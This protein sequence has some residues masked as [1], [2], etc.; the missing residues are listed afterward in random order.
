[1][2]VLA[3][4]LFLVT[5]LLAKAQVRSQLITTDA[6]KDLIPEGIA[7]DTKTGII[8]ISSINHHSIIAVD[9]NGK[10]QT[11]VAKDRYGFL[12]GLGM[13]VDEKRNWLWAVS[14]SKDSSGSVSKVHAFDIKT[15]KAVQQYTLKDTAQHLLNDL[16]IARD[17]TVYLTDTYYSAVYQLSPSTQKLE[18]FL[19]SPYLNYPNGLAFGKLEQLYIA[20]YE[21]GLMQ[22]NTTTKDLKPL[23]G[24]KDTSLSHGLDGLVFWNNTLIGVYNAGPDRSTNAIVQY[25]LNDKGDRIIK[26]ALLAKGHPAFYEPTTAAIA[27]TRLIVLA[28]SHLAAYNA[29]QTSTKGIEAQLTPP[30][31]VVCFL[32]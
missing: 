7:I 17:G 9:T 29:N 2:R 1:M 19:K 20:T 12:E 10:H 31:I 21:H 22:L 15:G 26:E 6:A 28:N 30:A 4:I 25:T 3:F 5:T 14:N 13:K 23:T 8:Y 11:F 27:G 16:A 18:L 24:A 32:K